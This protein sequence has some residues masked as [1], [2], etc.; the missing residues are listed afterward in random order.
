MDQERLT[1]LLDV[2][3]EEERYYRRLKEL[4][5]E[6]RDALVRGEIAAVEQGRERC[7]Q[8]L[9]KAREL[10]TKR[11]ELIDELELGSDDRLLADSAVSALDGGQAERLRHAEDKLKAAATELY[12]ENKRN[13]G[14]AQRTLDYLSFSLKAF[15][16]DRDEV[17]Y[18][19]DA[20]K[21]VS[22][23]GIGVTK[24]I[25]RQA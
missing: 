17:T 13:L 3:K 18:G 23:G 21:K 6:E 25:D 14:A 22:T 19:R 11:Q 2:I 4:S 24:L 15:E 7:E 20:N 5:L 9:E 1:L 10:S 12:L 16:G 8:D